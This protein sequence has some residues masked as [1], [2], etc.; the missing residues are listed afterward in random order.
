MAVAKGVDVAA[1]DLRESLMQV[2]DISVRGVGG[3]ILLGRRNRT[4]E[5]HTWW[6]EPCSSFW[7]EIERKMERKRKKGKKDDSA[8]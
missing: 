3:C 1:R 4:L 8:D 6:E 2:E 7:E 5:D